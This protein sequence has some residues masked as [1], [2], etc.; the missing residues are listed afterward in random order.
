MGM[1]EGAQNSQ[2]P[3]SGCSKFSGLIHFKTC[4]LKLTRAYSSW[5]DC[6][7]GWKCH[8]VVAP[9]MGTEPSKTRESIQGSLKLFARGSPY[10]VPGQSELAV[11]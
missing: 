10:R 3:K 7:Y 8:D 1:S 4:E 11:V 2:R 5:V 6:Q 9:L